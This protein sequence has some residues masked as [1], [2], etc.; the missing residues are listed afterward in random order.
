MD[1]AGNAV[2]VPTLVNRKAK[3]TKLNLFL[4]NRTNNIMKIVIIIFTT[5]III[6]LA[7]TCYYDSQEFLFP[8]ISTHCDSTGTIPYARVDSVLKANCMTCHDGPSSSST[9]DLTTYTQV[10]YYAT[11][12]K[13]GT[14]ILQGSIRGMTG[15]NAMPLPPSPLLDICGIRIIEIWIEQ[16]AQQKK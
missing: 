10:H 16:G 8:Q 9:I 15:F 7:S 5:L 3:N 4:L 13:N 1:K 11:T 14:S 2:I 6:I 12:L